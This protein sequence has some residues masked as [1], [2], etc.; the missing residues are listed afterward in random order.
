MVMRKT[1]EFFEGI[2]GIRGAMDVDCYRVAPHPDLRKKI[3]KEFHDIKK[4]AS[5]SLSAILTTQ[6]SRP[7]G[8]NDGLIY[9]GT[10]FPTG[11]P[12]HVAR[13]AAA[14][15]SPLRG[16]VRVVVVLVDFSDKKYASGHDVQHFKDLFFSEGV[17]ATG[18]VRE[19]Y[20]EVTNGL[21]EITGDVLG[22]YRMSKK[23]TQ[24]ANGHYGTGNTDPNARDMA[25]EAAKAADP[26]VSYNIYD[27]DGDGFVD[28][29]IVIHAGAGAEVTGNTNDIW[30]HKW[31][32][33]NG[34]YA[35][36]STHLYAYLTVPE[37]SR[38]GVCC[39]ELG[40]LLFGFPDLYDTDYSSEGIGNWCLMSGGSWNGNGDT[41]SH[42]SAW[43]KANQGWVSTVVQQS[44]SSVSIQNVEKGHTI[45]RLWKNGQSG[46]EYFLVENRQKIGFDAKIPGDGILIWHVDD[47]IADNSNEVHPKVALEQADGKDDLLHGNNR[48]DAGDPFPGSSNDKTFNSK[49]NPNSKSYAGSDTCVAVDNISASGDTMTARL[50]V[51]CV[52]IKKKEMKEVVKEHTKEHLKEPKEIKETKE[53]KEIKERGKELKEPKEIKEQREKPSATE[54]ALDGKWGRPGRGAPCEEGATGDLSYLDARLSAVEARLAALEPFIAGDLRP[55]LREGALRYEEDLADAQSRMLEGCAQAKRSFDTKLSER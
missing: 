6:E 4:N 17:I 46:N 34:S 24:Y 11:T 42:P 54:K 29:F 32:F 19:F 43:C 50:S 21:V 31:V 3:M 16:T 44:N 23:L 7:C 35:A 15:R 48:G 36:D 13:S 14:D 39:H 40:H 25:L 52:P 20:K 37:D 18:S 47:S 27:N 8:F 9:P 28:A 41:P 12:A 2:G 53:H 49:S 26:D 5:E 30:S 45:Y 1:S 38:A 55:D 22:P 51:K 10:S 33:R